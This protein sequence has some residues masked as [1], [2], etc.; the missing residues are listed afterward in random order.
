MGWTDVQRL[1]LLKGP[2]GLGRKTFKQRTLTRTLMEDHYHYV[3]MALQKKLL[4]GDL[5]NH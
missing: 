1:G 4:Y 3:S 2:E 5:F